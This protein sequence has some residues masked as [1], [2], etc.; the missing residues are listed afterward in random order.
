M[1]II[2]YISLF[3]LFIMLSYIGI[4]LS[5]KYKNRVIELKEMK[6]ALNML[7]T[8][9]KFTYEPIPNIFLEIAENFK[10]NIGNI[11]KKSV[12]LMK[13]KTAGNAW[14][15]ALEKSTSSFKKE[16]VDI[17][18]NLSNLLGKT[19]LEGQI[20]EIELTKNFLETQI[21]KAEEEE[22]KNK[23]MYR[24]LGVILGLVIVII[25]I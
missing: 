7:E 6:N 20:S 17:L 4:I 9:M 11:F 1:I 10:N 18:K 15:K 25:L 14:Q 23:K 2:K 3:L 19:S 22:R 21:K 13:E 16:D 8:K 5:E 24:S 12:D